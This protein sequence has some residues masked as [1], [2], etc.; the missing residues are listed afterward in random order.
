[1]RVRIDAVCGDNGR[2]TYAWIRVGVK[3]G[4]WRSCKKGLSARCD[5]V[6]QASTV[7]HTRRGVGS[8]EHDDV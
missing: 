6:E 4:S 3:I 8:V 1:M 7:Q 2:I 5:E